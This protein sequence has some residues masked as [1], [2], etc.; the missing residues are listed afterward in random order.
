M[1]TGHFRA[2]HVTCQSQQSIRIKL[3]GPKGLYSKMNVLESKDGRL[4]KLD[5]LKTG[6]SFENEFIV[7]SIVHFDVFL[8]I[9]YSPTEPSTL[10]QLAVHFDK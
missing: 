9:H 10:S 3:D 6:R 5:G 1:E 8:A 7:S 4:K 2:K